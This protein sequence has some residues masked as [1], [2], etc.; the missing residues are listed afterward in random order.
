MLD[1]HYG[2]S[3]DAYYQGW[4]DA[5]VTASRRCADELEEL[6]SLNPEYTI[7]VAIALLRGEVSIYDL[8]LQREGID[9]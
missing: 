6:A 3:S 9:A 4:T 5:T 8:E 2:G 1:R 7:G